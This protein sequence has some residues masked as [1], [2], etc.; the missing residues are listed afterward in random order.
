MGNIILNPE[1]SG[2]F[3]DSIA[4]AWLV[5]KRKQQAVTKISS[6]KGLNLQNLG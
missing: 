4:I 6:I 1:F 5:L 3:F 2:Y